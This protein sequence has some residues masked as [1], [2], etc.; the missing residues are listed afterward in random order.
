MKSFSKNFISI[1]VSVCVA[2][3][4]VLGFSGC[5]GDG[6]GGA[7]YV[8]GEIS[9]GDPEATAAA[10]N[11]I[12]AGVV[13]ASS[14]NVLSDYLDDADVSVNGVAATFF[15]LVYVIFGT[16]P[17]AILAGD[18]VTLSVSRGG[19]AV[20]AT[21]AMPEAPDITAPGDGS[22]HNAGSDIT[23]T[24]TGAVTDP[25]EIEVFVDEDYT[26]SGSDYDMTLAGDATTQIIPGGTLK[27]ATLDIPVEVR[28]V[29]TVTDF[30]GDAV[31]GST[32]EVEHASYVTIDTN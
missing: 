24:W 10:P 30:T 9:K 4:A 19:A 17:P 25:D 14:A 6:G 18:D 5:G 1:V 3:G 31:S 7:L 11:D 23:V 32:L 29:E 12:S 21:H 13:V 15:L 20:T 27:P 28:F 26:A 2:L 8:A 22:S 16:T